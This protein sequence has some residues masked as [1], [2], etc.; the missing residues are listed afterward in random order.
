[1][2]TELERIRLAKRRDTLLEQVRGLGNMMRGTL[3]ATRVRC[4]APNCECVQGEKHSKIHFSVRLKGRTRIAYVGKPRSKEVAALVGEYQRAW[5]LI[6]QL[7][8]I[9]LEL[10]RP[11]RIR[12]S[13]Q[14]ATR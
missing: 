11:T 12:K 13:G 3:Y 8:E 14:K 10:L 9:N 7:T 2:P 1:M 6:E 4:G 5:Q